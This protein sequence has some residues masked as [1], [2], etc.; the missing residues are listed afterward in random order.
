MKKVGG[1]LRL[2][3][4]QY[5]ELE[6]FS[7]FGS[8]LDKTTQRQLTRGARTAEV[9]KQGQYQPLKLADQVMIIYLATNGFLDEL[10]MLSLKAFEA[11]F[12][13][14]VNEKYPNLM[15]RMNTEKVLNDEIEGEL[16]KAGAEFAAKFKAKLGT[17]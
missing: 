13:V 3:L 10:P 4:A 17:T 14:F 6:A 1:R 9:L 16:K 7:K 11:E 5:R 15:H 8:D 12:K 2:E